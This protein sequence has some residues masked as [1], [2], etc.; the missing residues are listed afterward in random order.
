[1]P[2]DQLRRGDSGDQ[3]SHTV[4]RSHEDDYSTG[5]NSPVRAVY[6]LYWPIHHVSDLFRWLLVIL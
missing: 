3:P 2:D 4:S 1:M 6:I 5:A